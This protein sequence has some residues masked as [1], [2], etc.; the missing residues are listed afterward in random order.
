M[1]VWLAQH[2]LDL[3]LSLKSAGNGIRV[4]ETFNGRKGSFKVVVRI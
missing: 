1:L 2:F 3:R 4:V